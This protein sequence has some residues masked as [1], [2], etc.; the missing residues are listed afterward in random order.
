M[1]ILLAGCGDL[2]IAVGRRFEARG[3]QVVG[4]RRRT[5]LLP[6]SFEKQSVD[7]RRERPTVADDTSLV[8]VSL[9]AGE[10]TAAAYEESYLGGLG[11][12]LDAVGASAAAPRIL[13]VSSTAVY[14]TRDGSWVDETT[15]AEP[16][17]PTG[18]VLRRTEELLAERA[19]DAP[20]LRLGGIYGP[21]RERLIDQVRSGTATIPAH[22]QH[23]NRIHRDD[24]AAAIVHLAT[25]D[26]PPPL[27]VGVDDEPA[28]LG[29]VLRFLAQELG[30]PEPRHEPVRPSEGATG[31]ESTPARNEGPG[32]KRL[33]NTLLR[34]TGFEFAYPTFREGYRALLAGSPAAGVR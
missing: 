16:T 28:E 29:D 5:D 14:G 4:V 32:D 1:S 26:A 6:A 21:G 12:V 7:L 9:T 18:R 25:R 13:L 30:L 20:I 22:P 24:A 17:S 11:H 27:V 34:S 3:E 33:R 31:P 8:V 19:G 10:R 15:P 23:T 2:G